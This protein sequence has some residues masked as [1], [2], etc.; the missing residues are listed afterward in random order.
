MHGDHAAQAR[1]LRADGA[2]HDPGRK[3]RPQVALC[4]EDQVKAAAVRL[5]QNLM[6]KGVLRIDGARRQGLQRAIARLRKL[7]RA[8]KRV[9]L[10]HIQAELHGSSQTPLRS[11]RRVS[12][13]AM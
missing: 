2:G 5:Q 1:G 6:A 8:G 11:C 12:V 3:V 4:E 10:C 13:F 9:G 7:W